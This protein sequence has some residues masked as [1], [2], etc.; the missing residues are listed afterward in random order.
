MKH[1]RAFVELLSRD[2]GLSHR[3]VKGGLDDLINAGLLMRDSSGAYIAVLKDE[4]PAGAEG[5]LISEASAP[6]VDPDSQ[7][8]QDEK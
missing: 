5:S 4:P 3:A 1:P 2:T 7:R 6:L 8:G